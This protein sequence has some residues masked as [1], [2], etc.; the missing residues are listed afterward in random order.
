[1]RL[2]FTCFLMLI[3]AQTSH[4]RWSVQS[5]FQLHLSE[6]TF[7]KVIEDFWQSLQGKQTVPL[8]NITITPGGIPVQ[9]TGIRAELDYAFPLPQRVQGAREWALETDKLSATLIVDRISASQT[10]IR[11]IDG[12]IV[13]IRL[14]AECSNIRLRLPEG[15]ARI[16]ARIRAQVEQ[17]QV[18]LSLPHFDADWKESSWQ[19]LG[20]NCTG[21]QGFDQLV[22]QEALKALS[23]FQNFDHEVRASLDENFEKWSKD[24]SL[25]LLSQRELPSEKDY[26]KI[27]YEPKSAN[28]TGNGLLLR[29]ELRFEYPFVAP[30]QEIENKFGIIAPRVPEDYAADAKPKLILPFDTIRAL[31]MGEYFAQKLEYSM[32]STD[33]SGFNSLMQSRWTQFFA[34]PHLMSWPKNTKFAFQFLP[35]GPPS[36]RDERPAGADGVAGNLNLPLSMRMYAPVNGVYTPMVEFRSQI[37]GAATIKLLPNGKVQLNVAT[38]ELPV[39]YGWSKAYLNKYRPSQRIAVQTMAKELKKSLNTDGFTLALPTITV[40]KSLKLKPEA[41]RLEGKQL[42]LDFDAGK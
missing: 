26:V 34:W 23:S 36:F 22:A 31:M 32:W 19:L 38:Q 14:D 9:I 16:E 13:E 27:F 29:G 40:G 5:E 12:I 24:A 18:K 39:Q 42:H 20:M 7:D 25:L 8:A 21:A 2:F 6:P 41:W 1:M 17:S 35:M 15:S 11:E 28:E 4:A 30:G 33:M 3:S 10:I 37:S